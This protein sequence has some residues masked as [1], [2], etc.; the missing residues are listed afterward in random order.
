MAQ[1]K[2]NPLARQL[3][4]LLVQQRVGCL[5]DGELLTAFVQTRD[6][7][8]FAG[9]VERH[10]PMVLRVRRRALRDPHAAEDAFQATF[11]VH[12][13]KAAAIR[14]GEL[15]ANWLFGVAHRLARHAQADA[16]ARLQRESSITPR[17]APDV[18]QEIAAGECS[19]LLDEELSRL[20]D[21]FRAAFLQKA[22]QDRP[23]AELRQRVRRLLDLL[24]RASS[25]VERL[26]LS[27]S[28]E[29]LER[30]A[31][32]EAR[33]HLESLAQGGQSWLRHEARAALLRA[34]KEKGP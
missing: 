9:L 32:A 29:V 1:T 16:A 21:R 10:G 28:L 14:R 3:Q 4:R 13:R 12:L 26:R 27:R 25:S 15:L 11:L 22:L 2:P 30:L 6:E 18:F 34:G 5:P 23:S 17:Q 19:A 20:P 33:S 31:T 8:A 7:A 24:E